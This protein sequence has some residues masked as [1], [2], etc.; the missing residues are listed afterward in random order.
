MP[1]R[2]RAYLIASLALACT[3]ISTTTATSDTP[4]PA[5]EPTELAPVEAQPTP[6]ADPRVQ[7]PPSDYVALPYYWVVPAR[8]GEALVLDAYDVSPTE[9][10]AY[11]NLEFDD[12]LDLPRGDPRIPGRFAHGQRFVLM[13][14]A[15]RVEAKVE[16][17]TLAMGD[18]I[19]MSVILRPDAP[20]AAKHGM[21]A[22]VPER[23]P[24]DAEIR[25][26]ERLPA[27]D[28][29]VR[30]LLAGVNV[31]AKA[32]DLTKARASDLEVDRV[33]L[34]GEPGFVVAVEIMG[35][36][37]PDESEDIPTGLAYADAKGK[38]VAW[39]HPLEVGLD[40]YESMLV[41]D[42]EGDGREELIYL[43]RYHEGAFWYRLTANPEDPATFTSLEIAGSGL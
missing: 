21:L 27:S 18:G 4:T 29:L 15:G 42:L 19:N 7:P 3:P 34:R 33:S 8:E 1:A 10:A 12:V 13:S 41:L 6:V 23:A 31:A 14:E 43:A 20:L 28:P 35:G 5:S 2:A 17:V 37:A 11:E 32:A 39:V 16:G 40:T 38:I 24:A 26:P 22:F 30:T 36:Q 9:Y 25:V